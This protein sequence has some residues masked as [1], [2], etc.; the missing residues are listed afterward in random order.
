MKRLPD[1]M[2]QSS[3]TLKLWDVVGLVARVHQ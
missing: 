1:R 2:L 3:V